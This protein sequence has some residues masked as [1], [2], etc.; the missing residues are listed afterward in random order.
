MFRIFIVALALFCAACSAENPPAGELRVGVARSA[1]S[2]DP[3]FATD[4]AS[5]R[6]QE[7]IH[8]GL[9]RLD[10]QFLPQPDL[11]KSW[12]HPDPTTWYFTLRDGIRF[13]DGTSLSADD[14][15]ATIRS[16]LNPELASPL[17]AGF[18]SIRSIKVISDK[19]L[20][21]HLSKPDAS[22]LTRLSLGILPEQLAELP[23]SAKNTVGCGPFR[24]LGWDQ[25]SLSLKRVNNRAKES[26]TQIRFLTVKDPVT[27]CLKLARGE[28]DFSQNDLPPALLTYLRQQ[29]HLTIQTTPST[30]FSYIGI[31]LHD[32][33]LDNVR[34]R[35][36]LAMAIDRKKLKKVLLGNLPVLAETV[37]TPSHWAS[38]SLQS[39]TF[40]PEAAEAILEA[41]GY[42]PDA[43]G[44]RLRLGYRTSTDPVR[45]QLVT[46]IAAQW[47]KIGVYIKIESMEW[48]GFYARIKRGDFQLF[49]LSWVSIQDPD[50]Y[51]WILHSSM[52]PPTGAN[53]GRYSNPRM[54]LWLD[55]AKESESKEERKRLYDLVQKQMLKDIVYIPL[56]YEPV[57]A[58]SGSRL[59]GFSPSANGSL[60]SLLQARFTD[61]PLF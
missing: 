6:I 44:V 42:K 28:I 41:E 32:P 19:E 48:G 58:V 10:D 53:R 40:D 55:Q 3:R 33:E 16:I 31:N 21:I 43:G 52:W 49:S 14:V 34:V 5:H 2:L 30:T 18:A 24:L 27:R 57:I 11:A 56:W 37:L 59:V 60:L 23:H 1:M 7:F 12:K 20:V 46:A 39:G 45:L 29:A 4:A 61:K 54:D 51:R 8:R 26:I 13:H 36:A 38:S 17:R 47:Q 25:N 15:V 35:R 9:V 22:I 50:I